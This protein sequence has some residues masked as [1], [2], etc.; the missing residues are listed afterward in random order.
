MSASERELL[1]E[2]SA[3][4][5]PG[6]GKVALPTKVPAQVIASCRTWKGYSHRAGSNLDLDADFSN[7]LR[8]FY[9]S[10][11]GE[12]AECLAKATASLAPWQK[13]QVY[14]AKVRDRE[15]RLYE[16]IDRRRILFHDEHPSTEVGKCRRY[17]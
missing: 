6:G 4:M 16:A 15:N 17:K 11:P 9:S 2:C 14:E 13:Q 5:R 12:Y 3:A 1:K 10:M 7:A 8:E